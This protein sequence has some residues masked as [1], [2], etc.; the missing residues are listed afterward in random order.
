MHPLK[1]IGPFLRLNFLNTENIKNQLFHLAKETTKEIFLNSK[2]GITTT[3]ESL[4]L[5]NISTD[6][7]NILNSFSPLQC[8]YRKSD[9]RIS[10]ID[11]SLV[12]NEDKFKRE[13]VPTSNAFM[14]LCLLELSDYYNKFKIDY[15]DK[16]YLHD[17]YASAGKNQLEF[18]A[19]YL[20]N[21]EGVFISKIHVT[22]EITEGLKF[23]ELNKKFKFSEQAFLMIAFYKCSTIFN[24]KDSDLFKTFAKDI[25]NM[26]IQYKEDLYDL[27][28]DELSKLSLAFNIFYKYCKSKEC[29]T[30]LFDLYEFTNDKY[31]LN[32][33]TEENSFITSMLCLNS[34]M[35]F[36]NTGILKFKENTKLYCEKLLSFYK[37]ELGIFIKNSESKEVEFSCDEIMLYLLSLIINRELLDEDTEATISSIFNH[38]VLDSGIIKSWPDSPNLNDPERYVNFSLSSE[39]L[40]DEKNFKMPNIPSPQAAEIASVFLKKV[41]YKKKNE[42]FIQEKFAFE[43]S[44]NMFLFFLFIYFFKPL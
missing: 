30:M 16:Y 25:F 28:L 38:Q 9:S 42:S 5:K 1:Y 6:D 13:L 43:S 23:Q 21:F 29:E 11:N 19:S 8:I 12:W 27:S 26:F 37:K 44:K 2:F 20:R 40:I 15:P 24:D 4:K 10:T 35:I 39:D 41:V 3:I 34:S 17:L 33:D 22:D 32:E 36:E 18:Y 31:L 14:T 7:I